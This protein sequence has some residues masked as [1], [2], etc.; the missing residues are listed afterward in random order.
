MANYKKILFGLLGVAALALASIIISNTN[1]AQAEN[2]ENDLFKPKYVYAA[3]F[4]CGIMRPPTPNAGTP[5]F[6]ET[7]VKPANYATKINFHNP[8]PWEGVGMYKKWVK[9]LLEPEQG[10]PTEREWFHLRPDHASEADCNE[11]YRKLGIQPTAA[12]PKPYVN[13]WMIFETWGKIDVAAVYTAS[14]PATAP[15][16]TS[17]TEDVEYIEP[18]LID[19]SYTDPFPPGTPPPAPWH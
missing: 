11:I 1:P 12:N 18:T 3:K 14:A 7:P 17:I 5:F 15:I 16:G 13:G 10:K 19:W 6:G 4:V 9:A 8:H 2:H